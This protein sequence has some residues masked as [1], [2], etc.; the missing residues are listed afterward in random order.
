MTATAS[1]RA[2]VFS[3]DRKY[4][5]VLRRRFLTGRGTVNFIMLNP[6]TAD[7]TVDDPTIRR[8][9]RFAQTWGYA[10]LVVTNL[11]AFRATFP[12]DVWRQD[13]PVGPINDPEL[14]AA[15]RRADLV[16]AAWGVDGAVHSRESH[17]RWLL[18]P[19]VLHHLGLTKGGH[20]KHPLYLRAD[21]KPQP[22]EGS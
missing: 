4:R 10:E 16:V 6:S 19:I 1:E 11:F 2:A 17:V 7:E 21:T 9:I 5:Y 12:T 14:M 22:W 15:A 13:D 20:P 8:C 3:P 18:R